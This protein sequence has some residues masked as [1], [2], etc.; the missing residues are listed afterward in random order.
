MAMSANVAKDLAREALLY[1]EIGHRREAL[2]L[3][4]H[5]DRVCPEDRE[6]KRVAARLER[7]A[8]QTLRTVGRV[9]CRIMDW[10]Y[11]PAVIGGSVGAA[12]L[13]GNILLV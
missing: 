5:A 1:E 12:Y 7:P 10:L 6:I 13:L 4:R 11:L 2:Q 9:G 8:N 3:L